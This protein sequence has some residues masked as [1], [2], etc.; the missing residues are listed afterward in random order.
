MGVLITCTDESDPGVAVRS[1]IDC[2]LEDWPT[3]ALWA[4]AATPYRLR[5]ASA[6]VQWWRAITEA[7]LTN[8]VTMEG[9][10][11]MAHHA[12][13]TLR[14]SHQAIIEALTIRHQGD[15]YTCPHVDIVCAVQECPELMPTCAWLAQMRQSMFAIMFV[16][17]G[18]G[19]SQP[20]VDEIVQ[21]AWA[22]C[23][24]HRVYLDTIH[25]LGELCAHLRVALDTLVGCLDQ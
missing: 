12:Y 24:R 14:A 20:T 25:G 15:V 23:A 22:L 2:A 13:I 21:D 3:R 16:D 7:S 5:I 4:S 8:A 19:D 18:Q 10:T 17:V 9:K 11:A 1:V 6:D